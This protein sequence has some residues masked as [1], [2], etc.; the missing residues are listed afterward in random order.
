MCLCGAV[1]QRVRLLTEM[2]V[3]PVHPGATLTWAVKSLMQKWFADSVIWSQ[4]WN[5]HIIKH[6]WLQFT[7]HITVKYLFKMCLCGAIGQRVRLL[8]ERLVDLAYPGTILFWKLL[9]FEEMLCRQCHVGPILKSP[10]QMKHSGLQSNLHII[11]KCFFK[12]WCSRSARLAVHRKVGGSSPPRD[13]PW[14][15]EAATFWRNGSR[16]VWY[17]LTFEISKMNSTSRH[18]LQFPCHC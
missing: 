14:F 13:D 8:A 3:V 5:L 10:E 12:L 17:R 2:L 9:L 6:K 4:F 16:R 15:L 11:V 18:T 7:L 1:G